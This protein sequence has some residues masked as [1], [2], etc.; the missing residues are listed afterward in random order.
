MKVVREC[1]ASDPGSP[2]LPTHTVMKGGLVVA[3]RN[4]KGCC[5]S[6]DTCRQPSGQ[7]GFHHTDSGIGGNNPGQ[8]EAGLFQ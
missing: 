3:G 7:L 6:M 2:P 8:L 5:P 4:H 1:M